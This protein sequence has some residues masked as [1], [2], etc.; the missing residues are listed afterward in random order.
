MQGPGGLVRDLSLPRAHGDSACAG[1]GSSDTGTL[2]VAHSQAS[3]ALES[4]GTAG[5]Q[6][7]SQ[8]MLRLGAVHR[9]VFHLL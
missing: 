7:C 1:H 9:S 6:C 4:W 2:L 8:G 5:M 3:S